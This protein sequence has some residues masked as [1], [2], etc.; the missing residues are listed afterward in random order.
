MEDPETLPGAHVEPAH[1]PLLVSSALGRGAGQVCSTDHD[2][3]PRD[4]GRRVEPDLAGDQIHLLIVFKLQI[5]DATLPE[6]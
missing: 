1:V 2:D 3:I 5:D 4:N 6:R